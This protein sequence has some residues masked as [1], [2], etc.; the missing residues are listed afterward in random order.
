MLGSIHLSLSI[1]SIIFNYM[2]M[3]T[4]KINVSLRSLLLYLKGVVV[5]Y[6]SETAECLFIRDNSH[7][8][9]ANLHFL[10]NNDASSFQNNVKSMFF[11]PQSQNRIR[12]V[13][14]LTFLYIDNLTF[15]CVHFLNRVTLP[16]IFFSFLTEV[17]FI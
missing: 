10:R 5:L 12:F 1:R 16:A 14:F 15:F 9:A 7:S 11:F 17:L 2:Y 8:M 6:G 13:Q 4:C 3:S